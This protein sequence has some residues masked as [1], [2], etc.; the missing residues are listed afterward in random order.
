MLLS[1]PMVEGEASKR[2]V[3]YG[4]ANGV[5]IQNAGEKNAKA[6]MEEGATRKMRAQV[7]GVNKALLSV[8]KVVAAGSRVVFDEEESYIGK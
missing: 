8:S 1:V 7:C 3:E 6:H 4:V 5:H 2:D